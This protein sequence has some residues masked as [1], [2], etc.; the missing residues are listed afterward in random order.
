MDENVSKIGESEDFFADDIELPAKDF[1]AEFK[2]QYRFL[3]KKVS[4]FIR[5]RLKKNFKEVLYVCLEK[6]SDDFI[7]EFQKQYPDKEIKVIIP[8]LEEKKE[9]EKTH[10]SF[11]YY[12][13]NRKN[14]AKLYKFPKDS[15]NIEVYGVYTSLFGDAHDISAF[16]DIRYL[17]PF[18]KCVRYFALKLRPDIIH[19]DNI[20]FFLGAEFEP[21]LLY[22]IKVF[23]TIEDFNK[24]KQ[25]EPFWAVLNIADKSGMKRL[26]RD[27]AVKKY[28]AALFDFQIVEQFD[29]MRD[30]LEFIYLN[31]T[32]F[33]SV[34]GSEDDVE[35][36]VLFKR[37]NARILAMFPS[38]AQGD[39]QYYNPM[40]ITLKK[41]DFWA[42]LSKSYYHEIFEHPEVTGAMHH[43]ILT[44]REKSGYVLRGYDVHLEKVFWPYTV[45]TF[46]EM[47]EK[48][49]RYL[50]K[51]FSKQRI[52]TK[53][54]DTN[55][56]ADNEIQV[57]GYLDAFYES[58]LIFC[59]FSDDVYLEGVD[60]A[61]CSV[62][63]LFELNKNIQVIFNIP[64]GLKNSYIKSFVDFCEEH[65]ALNGR[66]I[67]LDGKINTPQF[68][69]A[70]DII[71]LPLR[72]NTKDSR[73]IKAMKYG[74]IP[75]VSSIGVYN[76]TIID[77][78]DDMTQGCGFKTDVGLNISPD[79]NE[80]YLK[81]VLKAMSFFSQNGASRNVIVKNC[82]NRDGYWN[83]EILQKYNEI[84][85]EL[86]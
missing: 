65:S 78:F 28:I 34:V 5:S 2:L 72:S 48:N 36:N 31:Y 27:K 44:T 21:R 3:R 35:G 52:S 86:S 61:I 41:V 53:F 76:D 20:P 29:S 7:L 73:H 63:K 38:L 82:M 50:I 11:D 84:Y 64:N 10:L 19:C 74:C 57:C 43:R 18:L 17:S 47:R 32:T 66:W 77:I 37:L 58:A 81:A 24:V 4:A 55:L 1:R 83:F 68:L 49:K 13:Q 22:P 75:V 59:E 80:T 12:L 85:E 23:Q 46:R 40:D 30:C 79:A 51:E 60:I 25:Y 39:S 71:L 33:R 62:L 56:F 6:P 15:D 42:V 26:C 70:A 69:A 16:S 54:T 67:F 9:L 8:I 14:E 45:E